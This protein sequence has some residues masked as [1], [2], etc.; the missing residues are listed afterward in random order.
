MDPAT[1]TAAVTFGRAALAAGSDAF[2]AF[3]AA[4]THVVGGLEAER[5]VGEIRAADT[6]TADASVGAEIGK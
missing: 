4:L 3:K 5:L 6:S 2:A 1:M